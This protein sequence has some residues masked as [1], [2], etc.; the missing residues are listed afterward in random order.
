MSTRFKLKKGVRD[1]LLATFD[2]TNLPSASLTGLTIEWYVKRTLSQS[3]YDITKTSATGSE[4]EILDPS[5]GTVYVYVY[6][7]DTQ[8]LPPG[9]YFW[10]F[11]LYTPD[12]SV[13][14]ISPDESHGDLILL[15][16]A[17]L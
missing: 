8:N 2:T 16:S 13:V 12:S 17:F 14:A 15:N 7:Q 9:D 10:A 1:S 3:S 5:A 6:P 4:I 11:K